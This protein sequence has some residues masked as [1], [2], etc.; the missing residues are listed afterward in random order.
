[1]GLVVGGLGITVQRMNA[2]LPAIIPGE[3][4]V[5][6]DHP[7]RLTNLL[8]NLFQTHQ[9][10]FFKRLAQDL[11]TAALMPLIEGYQG[12]VPKRVLLQF[13]ESMRLEDIQVGLGIP[14]SAIMPGEQPLI[15]QE[16]VVFWNRSDEMLKMNA[17]VDL[18]KA[19]RMA[20][21]KDWDTDRGRFAIDARTNEWLPVELARTEWPDEFE[22]QR[23][24]EAE[25][26]A[27]KPWWAFWR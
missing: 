24:R 9:G 5:R 25:V 4:I 17:L 18:Q 7:A 8:H 1:M 6:L 22:R 12:M 26:N 3:E 21:P 16:T 10:E 23:R 15:T 13:I 11:M 19:I 27:K 14:N 2:N 20:V